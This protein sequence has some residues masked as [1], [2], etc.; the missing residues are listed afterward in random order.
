MKIEKRK[1]RFYGS[2]TV[3][4]TLVVPVFI[5]VFTGILYLNQLLYCQEQTQCALEQAA[6]ETSLEYT[7]VHKKLAVNPVLMSA[8]I[9][10]VISGKEN[11]NRSVIYMEKSKIDKETDQMDFQA[12]YT[13]TS[14]ISIL[15][16]NTFRF[17]ERYYG[18]AFTGVLTRMSQSEQGEDMLV[19]VTKTGSVYHKA[20][21]CNH[22]KLSLKV[23]PIKELEEKRS[24]DGSIYYPCE[25]CCGGKAPSEEQKVIICNYGNR[26]HIRKDCQKISRSIR[27][28]PISQVNGRTPCKTCANGKE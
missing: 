18:R 21:T 26:Y 17:R 27:E 7:L 2:I 12:A 15:G 22:L 25:K 11:D 5:L 4:A 23:V 1:S 19:Y 13:V 28:I 10:A 9:N 8:K 24:Q 20:I 14:P 3:E 6:K 16:K